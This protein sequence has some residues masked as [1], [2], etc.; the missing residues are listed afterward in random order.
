MKKTFWSVKKPPDDVFTLT[1]IRTD[2]LSPKGVDED[3]VDEYKAVDPADMPPIVLD[4]SL[5]V[6]DGS[7]RLT[8]A[9]DRGD[10]T[11]WAYVLDQEAT[12][13]R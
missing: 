5:W 3:I 7:H 6:I 1:E 2:R 11:I 12:K 13:V 8:A 9:Q 10:E 4:E